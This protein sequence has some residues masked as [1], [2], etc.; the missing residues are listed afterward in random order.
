[1]SHQA[2][3]APVGALLGRLPNIPNFPLGH[4]W[5]TRA[6]ETTRKSAK[7]RET[8]EGPRL[9]VFPGFIGSFRPSAWSEYGSAGRT[10]TYNQWINSTLLGSRLPGET[11]DFGPF[12]PRLGHGTFLETVRISPVL[13]LS[14]TWKVLRFLPLLTVPGPRHGL[15]VDPRD[16]PDLPRRGSR[17]CRES[18][19]Q[20][21]D[22][23]PAGQL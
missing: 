15:R 12:G 3:R 6:R 23:A 4:V 9:T 18:S 5:A 8:L 19:L 10:R 1:M 14:S 22:R 13:R 16:P 20:R 17:R 2:R 21:R 11:D 7:P